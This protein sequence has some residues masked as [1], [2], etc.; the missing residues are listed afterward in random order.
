MPRNGGTAHKA[1]ER[2]TEIW[3]VGEA[4]NGLVPVRGRLYVRKASAF[5]Y[6]ALR[7]NKGYVTTFNRGRIVWDD[8]A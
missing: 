5:S 6:R 1:P 7:R 2:P 8:D 3:W 4:A